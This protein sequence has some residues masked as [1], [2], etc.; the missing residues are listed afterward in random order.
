VTG[1][2]GFQFFRHGIARLQIDQPAHPI[3]LGLPRQF[4]L[5]DE[6]YWPA[7]PGP[8]VPGYTVLASSPERIKPT[9]D[10]TQPQVMF[11][12]CQPGAGRV[13]GC[14]PGHFTWTF[15]DPY[16]RI[17]LL[18]G[19]AWAGGSS[20]YRFDKLVLNGARVN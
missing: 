7:T 10:E 9:A 15:D 18:R 4:E 2:G 8:D 16:A 5:N 3:C 11:W 19:M 20:P 17:M 1:V 14:V 13:F 6:T 12:T